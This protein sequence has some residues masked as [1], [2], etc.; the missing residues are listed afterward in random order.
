M[1]CRSAYISRAA[2]VR[3]RPCWP[4]P[5]SWRGRNHGSIACRRCKERME[6]IIRSMKGLH[7]LGSAV[8][9]NPCRTA[10][11]KG[12]VHFAVAGGLALTRPEWLG[13]ELALVRAVRSLVFGTRSPLDAV[14]SK[15][16]TEQPNCNYP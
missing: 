11:N 12:L 6:P 16:G 1:A 10:H 3:R 7:S 15:A 9:P 14:H 4:L 5:P 8:R 2:T 13:H